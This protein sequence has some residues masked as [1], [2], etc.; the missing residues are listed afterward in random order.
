MKSFVYEAQFPSNERTF[1]QEKLKDAQKVMILRLISQIIS[2]LES[3]EQNRAIE[4]MGHIVTITCF[5][6]DKSDTHYKQVR[7]IIDSINDNRDKFRLTSENI[8]KVKEHLQAINSGSASQTF[9]LTDFSQE[10]IS[11]LTM[12]EDFDAYA[13]RDGWAKKDI[14]SRFLENLNYFKNDLFER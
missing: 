7:N 14:A 12:L 13:W 8:K 1:Y 11:I 3:S 4:I 2:D 6:L 10:F 9:E 5:S